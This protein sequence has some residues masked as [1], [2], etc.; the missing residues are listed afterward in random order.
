MNRRATSFSAAL[1]AGC[2]CLPPVVAQ[3][4][5]P[6]TT[7]EREAIYT[8]TIDKRTRAITELL[9]LSDAT[10]SNAVYQIIM[11]QYR[12]LRARDA[13]VDA[14]LQSLDKDLPGVESNRTAVVQLLSKRLHGEFLAKLANDLSPM[15]IE[16]VKDRMTYNKVQVTYSAY[17]EIVP[18][19]T[20]KDKMMIL[21][22]LKVARE[23]AMDGGS[24]DEKSA[25]FQKY[26][27]QINNR[28]GAGGY[29]V[30]KATQE[31]EARQAAAKA[32]S[33]RT[34]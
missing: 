10:K 2:C 17:G 32:A 6:F 9:S 31:W 24:A 13:A 30:V 28:L 21:D 18:G 26:K 4:S 22:T 15:Q 1:V 11:G 25:I 23:E 19:L 27:E 3:T 29:D 5:P 16:I 7:E 12:A 34:Q 14:M 8:T 20:D 33:S